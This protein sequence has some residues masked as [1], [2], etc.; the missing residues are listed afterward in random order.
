MNQSSPDS[1]EW[2]FQ[3]DKWKIPVLIAVFYN[4]SRSRE[5]E[6]WKLRFGML[7]GSHDMRE[8][9]RSWIDAIY[10]CGITSDEDALLRRIGKNPNR[11][12]QRVCRIVLERWGFISKL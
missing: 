8:V 11:E 1:S 10:K 12:V 3:E 4:E 2:E 5:S 9:D 6:D 7:I